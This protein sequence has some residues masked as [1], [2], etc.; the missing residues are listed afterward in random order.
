MKLDITEIMN[1]RKDRLDFSFDF[2]FPD[3]H[4]GALLPAGVTLAGPAQIDCLRNGR[5]RIYQS[6]FHGTRSAEVRMREMP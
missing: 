5:K 3:S 1:R 2:K 6:G 4:D